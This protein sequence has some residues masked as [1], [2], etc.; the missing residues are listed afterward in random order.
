MATDFS[1]KTVGSEGREQ[2][3][4]A[5]KKT[6]YPLRS[7]CSQQKYPDQR[8]GNGSTSCQQPPNPGQKAGR[9]TAWQLLTKLNTYLPYDKAIL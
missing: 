1:V 7:P 8:K 4:K 2:N 5:L 3:M 9:H 6:K